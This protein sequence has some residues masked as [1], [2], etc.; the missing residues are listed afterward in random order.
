MNELYNKNL[1]FFRN[2]LKDVYGVLF[3]QP[4]KYELNLKLV[5]ENPNY[6]VEKG[7]IKCNLHSVYNIEQ[8]MIDTFK[9]TPKD[10]EIIV[11]FGIGCGYAFDYIINNYKNIKHLIIIEPTNQIFK[12][13]LH[14]KDIPYYNNIIRSITFL[15]N[16]DVKI[17]VEAMKKILLGQNNVFF[18][19][20]V[21]YSTIFDEYKQSFSQKMI[22]YFKVQ[23]SNFNARS[24]SNALWM[25]NAI[26]NLEHYENSVDEI[27]GIFEDRIVIIVSAGPSLENNMHLLKEVAGRA[28]IIAIG[29]A[30]RVLDKNG[31]IP[32]FRIATDGL[33]REKV[34]LEGIDTKEIP[35]IYDEKLYF[36]ILN[37]YEA[38]TFSFIGIT[39]YID[40]YFNHIRGK[41]YS[42]ITTGPSTANAALDMVCKFGCKKVIFMGQDLSYKGDKIRAKGGNIM[43]SELDKEG[44][45]VQETKDI[46]GEVVYTKDLYLTM[47]Y[48]LEDII[49][50]YK[51]I[52]F[53]NASEG[54]LHIKGTVNKRFTDVLDKDLSEEKQI[55]LKREIK[56]AERTKVKLEEKYKA[57]EAMYNQIIDIIR[58][59]EKRIKYINKIGIKVGKGADYKRVISDIDYLNTF[60]NELE[61]NS[62]Y[63]EVIRKM[64]NS[65]ITTLRIKY[66]YNGDDN[67]EKMKKLIQ[68][69]N[70]IAL[71]IMKFALEG[72][73]FC[74][75]VLKNLTNVKE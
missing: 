9:N 27:A 59:S 13:M 75:Y 5:S 50:V 16:I 32:H 43:A 67:T 18:V 73:G 6:L 46:Y 21:C 34:L 61:A 38:E 74:E 30:I 64:L 56:N 62:F 42:Q 28:I 15:V 14:Y 52:D 45:K 31:I 51:T 54:G 44:N 25:K 2:R 1:E 48:I 57:I 41:E 72:K 40:K 23:R 26:L 7:N 53:I 24:A 49:E 4:S 35:L 29:S 37:S 47:K 58:I 3:D 69:N 55:D 8:E 68:A 66:H 11:L 71:L 60:E 10:S 22:E 19:Y 70:S 12:E 39:D 20:Q 63:T 36:E 65:Q 17:A 33:P